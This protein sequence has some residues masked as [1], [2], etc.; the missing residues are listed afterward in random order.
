MK[1]EN[2]MENDH[3]K[4]GGFDAVKL[5]K[6]FGTP[7]YVYHGE[8]IEENFKKINSAIPYE[9]KQIH[10]AIMCNDRIEILKI[11]LKLGSYIQANS[12]KEYKIA[13]KAGFPNEKISI[14]TTNMSTEDMQEFIKF[15]AIINFDSIEEVKRFGKLAL[16]HKA[17]NKKIGIRVFVHQETSGQHITNVP[18][19]PKARVGIKKEKFNELKEIAKKFDLKIIGV[20][21]YLASN[22]LNLKP[23]LKLNRFLVD[24]AKQFPDIEYINFGAGFGVALKPVEKD[25]DWKKYGQNVTTLMK[26]VEKFFGRK[27]N[28]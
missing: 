19:L 15:G 7:L 25:F 16:K 13:R 4:I 1:L 8:K 2:N 22:M 6:K 24:C 20:H 9:M 5:A 10:Y 27:I 14:T 12:L 3:F 11:L 18:Y 23:F 26:E 17:K 21:G 28:L